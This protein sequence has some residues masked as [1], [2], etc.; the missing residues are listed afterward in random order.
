MQWTASQRDSLSKPTADT[1]SLKVSVVSRG[2]STSLGGQLEAG[3][4]LRESVTHGALFLV[5]PRN[6]LMAT[7]GNNILIQT[8]TW[9]NQY[10]EFKETLLTSS[11]ARAKLAGPSSC[12]VLKL[13]I[14]SRTA[15]KDSRKTVQLLLLPPYC[16][17][18]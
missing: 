3:R 11:L 2:G 17:Y 14:L 12:Q 6:L 15:D 9:L 4:V 13:N 7:A 5:L 16:Q 10:R 18:S 1:K 8:G